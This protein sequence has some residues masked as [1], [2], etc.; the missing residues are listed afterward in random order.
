MK[1]TTPTAGPDPRLKPVHARMRE[2][3]APPGDAVDDLYLLL[4]YQLGWADIVGRPEEARSAKGIRPLLCLMTCEAV[5]GAGESAVP[6][7]TAIE[8]THEFSLIHDDIEDGDR[9]R[10]GRP[11]LWT[12][13][14]E[15]RAINAGDAL[16]A[17]ARRQITAG[18]LPDGVKLDLVQRYDVACVRLAEGQ[19]MD[20]MFEVAE[21]I[22]ATDYVAMVSRKTGGLLGAAASMG[23]RA[24]GADGA[25]ADALGRYGE[26][27]GVAFQIQDDVL[28]L[29]G[30]ESRTGKP[31]GRDLERR[32][33]TLPIVL[34]LEDEILGPDLARLFASP[35]L[36]AQ[37]AAEMAVR[38]EAAGLRSRSTEEAQ[39]WATIAL[40]TLGDVPVKPELRQELTA[41]VQRAVERDR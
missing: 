13:V 40:A 39:R 24:G 16:F 32:K 10:R 22:A 41:L 9:L 14:G 20:M 7:A 37:A 21:S 35:T 6:S 38:L 23:A 25:T 33:K 15:E 11:T 8:L 34:G 19:H 12:L 1:G 29:W 3:I 27:L 31:T 17:I 30:A 18:P 28:G 36:E 2:A 5:G 26:A 4:A